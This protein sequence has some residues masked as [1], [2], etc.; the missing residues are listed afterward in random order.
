MNPAEAVG[1]RIRDLIVQLQDR[2]YEA[3]AGRVL[4][5]IEQSTSS[6]VVAQRLEEL[7]AEA[8]RLQAAGERLQADNPVLRALL[9]DLDPVMRRNGNRIDGV[10]DDL[11]R[12][13]TDAAG[14]IVR[15]LALPGLDDAALQAMGIQWNVPDPEAVAAAVQYSQSEAFA[16]SLDRFAPDVMTTIQN[17]A[18]RGVVEGWSPLRIAEELTRLVQELPLA[19][20]NNI[21][22]TLQLTSYRD[23]GVIHRLAN[24]DILEYQIR[25]AVLD[26]RTCL[27]C[28][29]LHGTRLPL[30]ARV[31]DHH[32][33]RCDS[34]CQVRGFPPRE[35]QSGEDWFNSLD[36][37]QQ[38]DM[39]G[40]ANY[41]AWRA[42]AV[43]LSDFVQPYQSDI[44][45]SMIRQ[46]SLLGILGDAARQY[47]AN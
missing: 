44:Y 24:A 20:A 35:I 28:I 13:G 27:A 5:S 16:A 29:A 2:G 12:A 42:G 31:D 43:T 46:A 17:M 19:W 33:G 3:V 10:A 9:A 1:N 39:M 15:Q 47:Y 7:R 14:Q 25:I 38:R 21:M 4:L 23:A 36:E 26:T 45:G 37:G 32:Q 6:G 8:Q 11:Q 22:R 34:I 41:E 40:H 30:D 18:V